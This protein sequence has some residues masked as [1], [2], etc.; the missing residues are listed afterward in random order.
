M[1]NSL[2]AIHD[3]NDWEYFGYEVR[4]EQIGHNPAHTGGTDYRGARH[5]VIA[6][7][8]NEWAPGGCIPLPEFYGSFAMRVQSFVKNSQGC[9]LW[10]IGNEM[11]HSQEWPYGRQIHP[12]DYGSCFGLCRDRI[13]ALPGHE[14]DQVI[15]GAVAPYNNQVQY[16]GNSNGDWVVYFKHILKACGEFDAIALHTYGIEQVMTDPASEAMMGGEFSDLHAGFRAYQDFLK[17]IPRELWHLP[18]YI[19]ETNPGARGDPWRDADTGWVTAAY[20][21]IDN[22]NQTYKSGPLVHCLA[23]YSHDMRGDGMGFQHKPGVRRDF[24]RAV[25]RDYTVPELEKPEPPDP[26]PP[27]PEPGECQWDEGRIVEIETTLA[28]VLEQLKV[29]GRALELAGLTLMGDEG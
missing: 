1:V 3:E 18:V 5:T 4:V 20:E 7:L 26:E 27:D 13:K 28:D 11:N 23:L 25:D 29:A 22:W 24:E 14:S 12:A 17:A 10:I 16:P 15:V 6:R 2:N 8:Q 9:H 21:E 19:T